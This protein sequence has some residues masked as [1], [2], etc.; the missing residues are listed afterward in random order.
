MASY[1]RILLDASNLYWAAFSVSQD[2][3]HVLP[4]GEPVVTGGVFTFLKMMKRIERE[5]LS[6][7]GSFYI[8]FDNTQS[9]ENRRKEI[10]PEYKANRYKKDPI[11]Y[12]GLDFLNLILLSYKDNNFVIRSPGNEADDLVDCLLDSFGSLER[13]RVLLVS[14][15]GDWARGIRQSVHWM[16]F[17]GKNGDTI[18]TK[19]TF[20]EKKGYTPS[21]ASVCLYKA[22][23]GDDRDNIPAGVP[24]I[25]KDLVAKLVEDFENL[26]DLLFCAQSKKILYLNDTWRDRIMEAKGRLYLNYKL[27]DYLNVTPET[28]EEQL[29]PTTYEPKTLLRLYSSL[30]FHADK[31][32]PRPELLAKVDESGEDFFT[33]ED[34]S[35]V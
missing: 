18:Y 4:N 31:F 19:D 13:E 30:G 34:L 15:D 27:V 20:K 21:R 26:D 17:S 23:T 32:D 1:T 16:T 22:F 24:G 28:I 35:R 12:R 11:F 2:L 7:M 25:R 14:N 6:P 29:T 3:T 5:Y 8:L 9:V 10:D 33:F